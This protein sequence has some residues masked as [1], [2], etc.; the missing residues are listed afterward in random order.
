MILK[1]PLYEVYVTQC[2]SRQ[3]NLIAKRISVIGA[4]SIVN[5]GFKV[6]IG[7]LPSVVGRFYYA[8]IFD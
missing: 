8:F 7:C 2:K 4:N 3:N 6:L 1:C 5:G